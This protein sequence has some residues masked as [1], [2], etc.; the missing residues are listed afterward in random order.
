MAKLRKILSIAMLGMG[1]AVTVA[2]G[3]VFPIP[4]VMI[5][6]RRR[7]TD[8]TE[9]IQPAPAGDSIDL[10]TPRVPAAMLDRSSYSRFK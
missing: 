4:P 3:V 6:A 8:R 5:L 7:R 1:A 2:L 10:S 9:L